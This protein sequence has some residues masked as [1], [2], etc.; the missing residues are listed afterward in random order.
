MTAEAQAPSRAELIAKAERW[1]DRHPETEWIIRSLI[2]ALTDPPSG[3]KDIESAPR[4]GTPILAWCVHP[5]ARHATDDKDWCAPVVTQWITHNGGG[6][7]WNGIAGRF[8]H[9]RELPAPPAL[10]PEGEKT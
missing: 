7:T 3:W 2:A 9:W 4:D 5:H 1:I 6:W 8:T 10:N